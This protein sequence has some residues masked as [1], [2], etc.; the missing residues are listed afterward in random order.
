QS[1]HPGKPRQEGQR[2]NCET[3]PRESKCPQRY[4]S[5]SESQKDHV[6][7]AGTEAGPETCR[8]FLRRETGRAGS[9]V[10][11]GGGFSS[12]GNSAS[13]SRQLETFRTGDKHYDCPC[14]R[15]GRKR[16]TGVRNAH[17]RVQAE[18]CTES[19]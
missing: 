16:R 12:C 1:S 14:R 17:R 6:G 11:A 7:S 10:D 8:N 9:T 5:L 4:C 18:E 3:W 2:R 13:P 19:R 15:C